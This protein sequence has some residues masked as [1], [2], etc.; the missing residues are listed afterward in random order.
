MWTP[1]FS[2]H[3]PPT[4][5]G[6][7]EGLFAF[8]KLRELSMQRQLSPTDDLIKVTQED[9][10]VI[11][12]KIGSPTTLQE[13]AVREELRGKIPKVDE[14]LPKKLRARKLMDHKATSV[15]D[16]AFVL[17]WILSGPSPWERVTKVATSRAVSAA[18][19][20]FRSTRRLQKIRQGIEKKALEIRKR[21][22]HAVQDLA[23]DDQA[24]IRLTLKTVQQ[25]SLEH[26]RL[27][28][29]D[30]H[31]LSKADKRREIDL[32]HLEAYEDKTVRQVKESGYEA[33]IEG[34]EARKVFKERQK[35][36]KEAEREA[37]DSWFERNASPTTGSGSVWNEVS[38]ARE[39]ALDTFDKQHRSAVQLSSTNSQPGNPSAKQ[40]PV[41]SPSTGSDSIQS[42]LDTLTPDWATEPRKVKVYWADINDGLFASSWPKSVIHGSLEPFGVAKGRIPIRNNILQEYWKHEEIKS[43]TVHVIGSGQG[44]GWMPNQFSNGIIQPREWEERPDMAAEENVESQGVETESDPSVQVSSHGYEPLDENIV[45]EEKP[46]GIWGRVKGLFGR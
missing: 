41:S 37:I 22:A 25:L 29:G 7:L 43:K 4:P 26:H 39:N 19:M 23:H 40:V 32:Q 9:I 14:I 12:S 13:M 1:Y 16:A 10:D 15:A 30:G 31:S 20:T 46:K 17:D 18:E 6:A 44:D 42:Q 36:V 21:A 34:K 3:F 27:I 35:T 11:K 5:A 2:I 33:A 24:H 8:Q 38:L 28:S 45:L